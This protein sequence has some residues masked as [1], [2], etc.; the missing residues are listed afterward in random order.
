MGHVEVPPELQPSER[1][2]HPQTA[3]PP[4]GGLSW[5]EVASIVTVLAFLGGIVI[6]IYFGRKATVA[7]KAEAHPLHGRVTLSVRSS[8]TAIGYFNFKLHHH[9][10]AA[11]GRRR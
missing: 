6:T 4:P 11:S 1:H 9:Q 10:R 8:V 3:P 2:L 5:G 7:V